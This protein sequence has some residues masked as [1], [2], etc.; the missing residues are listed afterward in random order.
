VSKI[1]DR[2]S[3]G[4]QWFQA[5]WA[6]FQRLIILRISISQKTWLNAI[7][8]KVESFIITRAMIHKSYWNIVPYEIVLKSV[9][10][11]KI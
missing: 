1:D 3:W 9:L 7:G 8:L 5:N 10:R 6:H 2:N 11:N 4:K